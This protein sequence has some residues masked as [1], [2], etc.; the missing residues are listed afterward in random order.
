M[1]CLF[2]VPFIPLFLFPSMFFPFIT[3]KNFGFR[4]I[5][6]IGF[7][8]WAYLAA[9]FP[10]YRPKKSL[11]LYSILTFLVVIGL[12]D[13]FA[14]N[15]AKAFWSNYERMEGY[16]SL[17]H[18][19]A[20]FLMLS[21]V[22]KE[23]KTWAVLAATSLGVSALMV[24]YS[25]FQLGGVIT[26]SQGGVRLDGTFGNTLYLAVYMLFHIFIALFFV[27]RLKPKAGWR[28]ALYALIFMQAF[29]LYH[30]SARGTIIGLTAATL[31]SLAIFAI[32]LGGRYSKYLYRTAGA[33]LVA[34]VLIFSL[35]NTSFIQNSSTLGRIASIS[36]SEGTSGTRLTVWSMGF[37][38]WLHRPILGYGQEGYNYVFNEFFKPSLYNAEVWFDRSHNI[39]FD[40]LIAGGILGL[41]SYLSLLLVPLY[42]YRVYSKK[43]V[44]E[45]GG[46]QEDHELMIKE[47]ALLAGLFAGYFIHNFFVFD[48]IVSYILFFSFLAY[49]ANMEMLHNV[50][51]A[52]AGAQHHPSQ[53]D[54][55]R[56]I[57][58]SLALVVMLP[59]MY[60]ANIKPIRANLALIEAMKPH[61]ELGIRGNF[62]YYR[63]AINLNT[64]GTSEAREQLMQFSSQAANAKELDMALKSEIVSYAVTQMELQ[65]KEL[66]GD[67]RYHL[68]LGNIY[69]MVGRN[70]EAVKELGLAVS[71]SPK[72]QYMRF[73][74]ASVN[75]AK[76]DL[77]TA[78]DD[79]AFAYNL[80]KRYGEAETNYASVLILN[81][82]SKQAE[83]MLLGNHGTSIV[84]E[85]KIINAYFRIKNYG[86]V[87]ELWQKK[88]TDNPTVAE[89]KMRVAAAYLLTGNKSKAVEYLKMAMAQDPG[90][91]EQA[92]GAI[93]GIN[94]G[95][96]R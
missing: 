62:D 47:G 27:V 17:L 61:P 81:G 36:L 69:S 74:R 34:I 40:W 30:T 75:L 53:I 94:D 43:R 56:I 87:L 71:L 14:V 24:V 91:K 2:T 18:L 26:I 89:Y 52:Q 58:P 6:E 84:P 16:V 28:Y 95:T 83:E 67:A 32:Y 38:G 44:E 7:V 96:L 49:V 31:V 22:I 72:K 29:T 79:L 8:C 64:F 63:K 51:S 78:E 73:A 20:Y 15:P 86:K 11:V 19:A 13:L 70:D 68:F 66:P 4:I 37:E 65:S 77:K 45:K 93:R 46:K 23:T 35:A 57:L 3:G 10:Q 25:M 60:Y 80:D 39:F 92:E 59:V 9:F 50:D 76:G 85:E 5:V 88:M 12:A 55:R 21:T 90:L 54:P 82:K 48:N 1:T 41:A 42:V 33:I